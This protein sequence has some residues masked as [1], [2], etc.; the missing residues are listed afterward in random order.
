MNKL[1]TFVLSALAL[2]SLTACTTPTGGTG[3]GSSP[4]EYAD[5]TVADERAAI[6]VETGYTAAA[7]ALALSY[8]VGLVSPSVDLDVQR[9]DFCTYV[10]AGSY[11]PSDRGGRL[12]A[13]DCRAYDAVTR[14]RR[15]YDAG[16]ADSFAV[17]AAEALALVRQLVADVKGN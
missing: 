8:R 17:A 9:P 13:L 3:L 1:F 12:A 2:A 7:Q 5:L 10:L 4:G 6:A 14:M 16:Q 11:T 15:L